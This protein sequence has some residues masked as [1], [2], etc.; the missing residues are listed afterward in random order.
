[1]TYIFFNIRQICLYWPFLLGHLF[2]T[3]N[4]AWGGKSFS[5]AEVTMAVAPVTREDLHPVDLAD[6]AIAVHH[7]TMAFM[8]PAT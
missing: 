1:M 8:A 3:G 2:A 5:A 4:L 7:R 6:L